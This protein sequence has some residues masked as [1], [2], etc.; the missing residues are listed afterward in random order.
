[1]VYRKRKD[2]VNF[3]VTLNLTK[4]RMDIL[5][6]AV[7]LARKSDNISY[8]LANINCSL[9]VKLTNSSFKFFNTID[10]LKNL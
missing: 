7:D 8:A 4:T 3:R 2:C 6:E 9:H 1:M 5:K 10:D